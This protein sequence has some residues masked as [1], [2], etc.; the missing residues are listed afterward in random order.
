MQILLKNFEIKQLIILCDMNFDYSKN[1]PES[2]TK[3]LQFISRAYQLEQLVL[4]PTRV[5][6]RIHINISMILEIL[7]N[8]E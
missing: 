4:E 3:K 8:L 1:L 5:T 7:R 6:H 2:H